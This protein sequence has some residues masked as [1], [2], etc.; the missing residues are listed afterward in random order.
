MVAKGSSVV[1]VV[2]G[3]PG[4]SAWLCDML[5]AHGFTSRRA[6]LEL[7]VL[8]AKTPPPPAAAILDL[9]ALPPDEEDGL[10]ILDRL[11]AAVDSLPVLVLS[12]L[13][14]ADERVRIHRAGATAI[15][16]KPVEPTELVLQL[17]ELLAPYSSAPL[18]CGDLTLD[19]ASGQAQRAGRWL[20]LTPRECALLE[21]LLRHRGQVVSRK[22]LL[23]KVWNYRFDP[24]SSLVDIHVSR[25]RRKIDDCF[26]QP[27]LHTRHGMGYKLSEIP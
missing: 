7:A 18:R 10:V 14:L 17:H 11:R 27:L 13:G 9:A 1:L 20:D 21:L 26:P 6:S 19:P 24:H 2:G 16:T 22:V 25:L 15:L 23:E 3:G 5:A 12:A 8:W 4:S